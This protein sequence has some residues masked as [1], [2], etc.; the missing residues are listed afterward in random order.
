M[1]ADWRPRPRGFPASG[2]RRKTTYFTNASRQHAGRNEPE[3]VA[4]IDVVRT[5][6]E[7]YRFHRA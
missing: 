3:R 7:V 4:F 5:A 6:G 1:V 2:M